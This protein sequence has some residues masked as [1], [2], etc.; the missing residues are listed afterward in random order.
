[1]GR[2]EWVDVKRLMDIIERADKERLG[3]A[4]S[5][6]FYGDYR[7]KSLEQKEG[8]FRAYI[9]NRDGKD[10]GVAINGSEAFC[11][12][13]DYFFTNEGICKH[14]LMLS[15]ALLSKIRREEKG[16]K[17]GKNEKFKDRN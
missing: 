13:P 16:V 1:M 17:N 7:V 6:L 4:L 11:H 3:R 5:G 8:E 2:I 9:S 10:Y 14:I 15:F 12:C